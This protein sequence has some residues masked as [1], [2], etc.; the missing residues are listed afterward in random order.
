MAAVAMLLND[1]GVE[2]DQIA[3]ELGVDKMRLER[4]FRAHRGIAI[5]DYR[6]QLRLDRVAFLIAKGRTSLAEAVIAAGFESHDEFQ[7]ISRAFRRTPP[8]R[9]LVK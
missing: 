5:S 7:Q 4:M 9:R 8:S 6:N 3:R 2:R 1:P